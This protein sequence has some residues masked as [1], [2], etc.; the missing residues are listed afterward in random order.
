KKEE[1]YFEALQKQ[2]VITGQGYEC[3]CPFCGGYA[4]VAKSMDGT[5]RILCTKCKT[6]MRI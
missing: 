4:I 3:D 6:N 2:C 1:K 5:V